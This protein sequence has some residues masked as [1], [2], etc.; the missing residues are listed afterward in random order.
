MH[1][2]FSIG[3]VLSTSIHIMR[4][5]AVLFVLIG[6]LLMLPHYAA[7]YA[8]LNYTFPVRRLLPVISPQV[9]GYFTASGAL[10]YLIQNFSETIIV[11]ITL[12]D[13][14]GRSSGTKKAWRT[15]VA[16][17]L[18]VTIISLCQS[19]GLTIGYVLIG[20][21]TW[22]ARIAGGVVLAPAL[23]A[24]TAWYVAPSVQITERIGIIASLRRSV[25]LT[26]GHRLVILGLFVLLTVGGLAATRSLGL[27]LRM[28]ANPW[29]SLAATYLF[30]GAYLAILMVPGA[31]IYRT[32]RIAHEG[33][34]PETIAPVFD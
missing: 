21:H 16:C 4:G 26:S 6:G 11:W 25:S 10:G 8:Q 12:H 33:P 7:Y 29:V 17:L 5:R 1:P 19:L 31:V 9:A 13:L 28:V 23:A 27:L 32:L 14:G 22:T 30:Q 34:D 18:S 24:M 20:A 2:D 15:G 3:I